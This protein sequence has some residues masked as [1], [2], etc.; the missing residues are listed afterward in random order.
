L[1]R[2]RRPF[3]TTNSGRA[4]SLEVAFQPRKNSLNALRLFFATAVIVSHAWP[5]GGF[6]RDPR[7]GDLTVGQWAVGGFFV[8]SGYLITGSR[9]TSSFSG[10][11][12]RRFLRIFPGLW[13]CLLVTVTVFTSIALYHQG[14]GASSLIGARAS[15]VVNNALL[16]PDHMGVAGTP[17]AVPL[18]GDWNDSLW[19]LFYELAC[20]LGVGIALSI[21]FVKKKGWM[22]AVAFAAFALLNLINV[23]IWHFPWFKISSMVKLGTYFVAGALLFAYRRRLPF[24][25]WLASLSAAVLAV[26]ALVGHVSAFSAL[27]LAYLCLW[28]GVRLPLSRIGRKNDISYG[29][30]I[31]AFPLAQILVLFGAHKAGVAWF[32]LFCI[33]LTLLF[34]WVSS[35]LVEKPA[36]AL[37]RKDPRCLLQT[38]SSWLTR[39]RAEPTGSD[40]AE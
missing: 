36:L 5:I 35:I 39:R 38:A 11:L 17:R 20:Y 25:T 18:A 34:A 19:T 21:A 40:A 14:A 32:I 7:I 16:V 26:G 12:W 23:E 22:F 28:L 27:P 30:Y 4:R 24:S 9:V 10:F 13:A 29:T 8:I 33:A 6:G 3:R 1:S 37:K 31:Y 15:Y 2:L